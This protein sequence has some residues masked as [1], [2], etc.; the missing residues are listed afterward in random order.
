MQI[1]FKTL[2]LQNFKS[3]RDRT[4]EFGDTTKITGDNAVGKSTIGEAVSWLLYGIDILGSKLDPTPVTYEADETMVSLL[5]ND[6]QKD[7]LLSRALKKGKA[8][9][10]I[11][12]VP[13]KAGEFNEILDNLFN[14]DLFLSLFNP[15]YFFT[16][17]WTDQRAMVLQ[18]VTAPANKEVFKALP[19]A[20]GD[21]LALLVKKQSLT[22]LEKLHREKRT[23]LDK[24]YIAAESN[25]KLLKKQLE[26]ETP[27]VP[28]ESLQA[29]K[30]VFTKQL[31]E[32]QK[33]IDSASS[34]N[35]EINRLNNDIHHLLMKRDNMKENRWT[36]LRTEEDNLKAKLVALQKEKIPSSCRVCNQTLEGEA[37]EAAKGDKINRINECEEQITTIE[38]KKNTF[39][40]E[41][42][43]VNNERKSLE[44]QLAGL[45]FIDVSEQMAKARE[46]QQQ[47]SPIESE[48]QKYKQFEGKQQQ[49][50][51]AEQAEQNTLNDLNESIFIID[52][53]K[54]Y[55][56]KEAEL[57]AAKVDG[58]LD[59]LSIKLFEEQKNKEIKPTF[60]IQMDGKDY[61]KLSLSE[62]IRAGL[63]LRD[64]LSVQSDVIVPVFVDNAESITKFKEPL[65]QLIVSRVVAGKE[66]EVA[67]E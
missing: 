13:S 54:A 44:V 30:S 3:H 19:K 46:L 12:E 15:N 56:A 45:T 29:E 35:G 32:V 53:V 66:L 26:E 38:E 17:K 57:Q 14:K 34:T 2:T 31:N 7:V 27:R 43:K 61:R 10:Y 39:I 21:K 63:E 55:Y 67:I 40:N 23:K 65:G 58:L 52:A 4:V 6:G 20:Q 60:E 33:T 49:V 24:Q 28:I 62:S 1:K 36:P 22:D 48:I 18:Y 42:D 9:Y 37:L 50:K 16:M 41:Y 47:L 51:D 11:N 25:T 5:L 8:A 64:V 59:N